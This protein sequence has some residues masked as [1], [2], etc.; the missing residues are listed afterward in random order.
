MMMSLRRKKIQQDTG[1]KKEQ[2]LMPRGKNVADKRVG[3]Q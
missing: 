2:L 3:I 1:D